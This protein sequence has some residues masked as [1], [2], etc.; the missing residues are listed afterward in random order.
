MTPKPW[1]T[2][3]SFS[4]SET[5]TP[6]KLSY[7]LQPFLP[8]K[9]ALYIHWPIT[10]SWPTCRV[11]MESNDRFTYTGLLKAT[12][13]AHLFPRSLPYMEQILHEERSTERLP[14]TSTMQGTPTRGRTILFVAN[15]PQ[16]F[17][18]FQIPQAA[19]AFSRIF[20]QPSH[21]LIFD[22]TRHRLYH[23]R[24]AFLLPS[25]QTWQ[26]SKITDPGAPLLP[27]PP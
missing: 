14:L 9:D 7:S 10:C 13:L 18:A 24:L 23:P 16:G 22:L 19:L 15:N 17:W 3:L 6:G 5:T 21:S 1:N 2:I 26:D 11:G 27:P 12:I 20:V 25:S 4:F 8:L